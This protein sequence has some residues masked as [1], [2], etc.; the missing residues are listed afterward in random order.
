MAHTLLKLCHK[1]IA[2]VAAGSA[3][4]ERGKNSHA[5]LFFKLDR[6]LLWPCHLECAR[7]E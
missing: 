2:E 5:F 1:E 3:K 4:R 6:V 7:S